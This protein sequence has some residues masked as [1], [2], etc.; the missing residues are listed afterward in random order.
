MMYQP[1]LGLRVGN[2]VISTIIPRKPRQEIAKE[3]YLCL[4]DCGRTVVRSHVYLFYSKSSIPKNCGCIVYNRIK[5]EGRKYKTPNNKPKSWNGYGCVSGD[6]FSR[7]IFSAKKRDIE[8]EITPKDI[9]ELYLKQGKLCALTGVYIS[10]PAGR[11]Q[12]GTV[13][14]DRIDNHKGYTL[15]NIQLVHKTVNRMKWV[16]TNDEMIQI[17]ALVCLH[18]GKTPQQLFLEAA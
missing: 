15:E 1:S 12:L 6:W 2:L 17:C 16:L 4:C 9:W 10:F 5:R 14:V 13:S 8:L 7:I 18:T 11:G 3:K